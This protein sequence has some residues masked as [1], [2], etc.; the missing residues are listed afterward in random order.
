MSNDHLI[1]LPK[2]DK[3]YPEFPLFP[4]DNGC[5]AK[6]IRGKLHYFGPW[7]DPDAALA[8][9][10][11]ERDDLH[12]GRKPRAEPEELT[13]RELCNAFLNAKQAKVDADELSPL[14]WQKYRQVCD[15]LVAQMGKTRVVQDL[16][17]VDFGRLRNAMTSKW[18]PLRVRDFIQHIRSVLKFG[19]EA[20]LMK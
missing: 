16:R 8:R 10:L 17:P 2:P 5:W 7:A 15:L 6:K 4:H 9:Y 18:G 11:A 12:A 19:F 13:V 1:K 3:P 14:P 20:E